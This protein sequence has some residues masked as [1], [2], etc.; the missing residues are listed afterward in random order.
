MVGRRLREIRSW[1]G[2]SLTV[3]AELAGLSA[4]YLSHI[5]RGLRPLQRRATL[6]ALASALR[7][8]PSEITGQPCPPS[9]AREAVAHSTSPAL[10]AVLHD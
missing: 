3:T 7:V 9:S 1:R 8:A 6:E 10:R 4:G 5:E 2:L